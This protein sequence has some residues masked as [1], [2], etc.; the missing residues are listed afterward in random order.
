MFEIFLYSAIVLLAF[1]ISFAGGAFWHAWN[2]N[3]NHP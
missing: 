3:R 2:D 1:N